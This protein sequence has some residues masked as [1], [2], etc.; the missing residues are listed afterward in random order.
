MSETIA[1]DVEVRTEVGSK[2]AARLRRAGRLPAI[3]YGHGAEPVAV[4]LDLHN[5]AEMLHHGHRLFN[6]KVGKQSETLMVKALQYDHL[7]KDIVHADLVRVSLTEMV[8]V[9]VPIEL[10]GTAKG[11]HEG[12][13]VDEHLD[14]LEIECKASDIPEVIPV[15]VKELGVGDTIHAGDIELPEGMKLSTTPETLVLTCHL[16]AAAKSTEE[17]E[18][19]MPVAPEVITEKV[20]EE[21]ENESK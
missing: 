17:L 1:L 7:G 15:F 13:I 8:K 9:T 14:Y 6:V 19:E 18:E 20:D 16:V 10:K 11:A 4:S 3:V 5:F 2:H 12:G 21:G